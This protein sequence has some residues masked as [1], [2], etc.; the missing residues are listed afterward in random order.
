MKMLI[1]MCASLIL[2]IILVRLWLCNH[3]PF[4]LRVDL[5]RRRQPGEGKP[6]AP[7]THSLICRLDCCDCDAADGGRPGAGF[8]SFRTA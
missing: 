7:L 2:N 3:S 6:R 1:C 8:L 4:N 5:K